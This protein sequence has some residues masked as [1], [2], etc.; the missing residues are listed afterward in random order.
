[1]DPSNDVVTKSVHTYMFSKQRSK[2]DE[3]DIHDLM[4]L[5][6]DQK[7]DVTSPVGPKYLGQLNPNDKLE[8]YQRLLNFEQMT[9]PGRRLVQF[10]W[11][12]DPL[13]W[14]ISRWSRFPILPVNNGA[15]L[16]LRKR[17]SGAAV[18]VSRI[19]TEA[20]PRPTV[21]CILRNGQTLFILQ[22]V[23]STRTSPALNRSTG[24]R[25]FAMSQ[26]LLKR[27]SVSGKDRFDTSKRWDGIDIQWF[28]M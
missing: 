28:S 6:H 19:W 1:M 12:A 26:A 15:S 2:K 17:P 22:L 8:Q 4:Q 18:V 20:C 11:N 25:K 3:W 21:T 24:Q 5:E 7:C 23:M 13:S 14:Q 27:F 9:E 16:S 10:K